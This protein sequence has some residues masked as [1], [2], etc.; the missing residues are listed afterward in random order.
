MTDLIASGLRDEIDMREIRRIGVV[1]IVVYAASF[2]LTY[3]Q[4]F[5]M[6]RVVR[7]ITSGL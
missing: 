2:A 1:L 6:S 3:L 7:E 5:V 4:G